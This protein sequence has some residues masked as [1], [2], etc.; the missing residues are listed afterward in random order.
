[1]SLPEMGW[2]Y[3]SSKP[4]KATVRTSQSALLALGEAKK[5]TLPSGKFVCYLGPHL[6][7]F[8][9]ASKSDNSCL[10]NCSSSPA[11]MIETVP[12]RVST[13]SERAIRVSAFGPV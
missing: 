12:G 1:M 6:V 10:L 11:G 5:L 8:K 7:A 4:G 13:T 3:N 9:K 2:L